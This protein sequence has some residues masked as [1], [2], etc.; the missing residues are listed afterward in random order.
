M[1]LILRLIPVL[2]V[3]VLSASFA[4]ASSHTILFIGERLS[5]AEGRKLNCGGKVRTLVKD[6]SGK[7]KHLLEARWV[8]PEGR[9]RQYSK[10]TVI[11][12]TEPADAWVWPEFVPAGCAGEPGGFSDAGAKERFGAWRV[13]VSLDSR[14]VDSAE[15]AGPCC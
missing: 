6:V 14:L 11:V 15:F 9:V 3:S 1:K 2:L 12:G 13:E 10:Q 8:G 4:H 5:P 7:G